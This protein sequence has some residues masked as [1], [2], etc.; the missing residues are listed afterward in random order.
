MKKAV[1]LLALAFSLLLFARESNAEPYISLYAGRV[2]T[3]DADIVNKFT[4][5]PGVMVFNGDNT[6]GAKAG[7]WF[8]AQGSPSFGVQLEGNAYTASIKEIIPWKGPTAPVS[9]DLDF[10]SVA[11]NLMVRVAEENIRP[12]A[13][14]GAGLYYVKLGPATK[15]VSVMGIPGGWA[16]GSDASIGGQALVGVDFLVKKNLSLFL[17]YKW[18]I[19]QFN[20]EINP[21]RT[22]ELKYQAN[23][24]YGGLSYN[25]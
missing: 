17:E 23:Q 1:S 6:F 15:P 19:A 10:R 24:F 7:Y 22:L 9:G 13:G 16:G 3:S 11:A 8:S 5:A 12:Y 2:K 25:F 20:V 21:G 4:G 18:G 14:V